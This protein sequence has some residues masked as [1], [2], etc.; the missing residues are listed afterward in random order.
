MRYHVEEILQ[1]QA[2]F[3]LIENR[4][5]HDSRRLDEIRRARYEILFELQI[6]H[7][8]IWLIPSAFENRCFELSWPPLIAHFRKIHDNKLGIVHYEEIGVTSP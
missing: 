1:A 4:N 6:G 8:S 3:G 5:R 7:P 2:I